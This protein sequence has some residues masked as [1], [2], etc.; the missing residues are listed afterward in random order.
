MPYNAHWIDEQTRILH[1]QLEAP[2]LDKELDALRRELQPIIDAPQPLLA[3]LNLHE[4][5]PMELF[6]RAIANLDCL[7]LPNFSQHFE[8]SRLAIT[9][10]GPTLASLLTLANQ[11]SEQTELIRPFKDES[12]AINWLR[13]QVNGKE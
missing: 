13:S 8:Q 7:P 5:N 4:L 10:G 6:T 1:I 2:L 9:G 11:I 12:T 3:L